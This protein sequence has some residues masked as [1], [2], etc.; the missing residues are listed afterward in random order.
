[1]DPEILRTM[2]MQGTIG[3]APNHQALR[4]NQVRKK[5]SPPLVQY[6]PPT[7]PNIPYINHSS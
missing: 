6:I 7:L 4:R 1:M 5:Y 3:Y 2:K